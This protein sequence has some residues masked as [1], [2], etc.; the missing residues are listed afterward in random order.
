MSLGDED[1]GA[2][3]SVNVPHEVQAAADAAFEYGFPLFEVMRIC[4]SLPAANRTFSKT[5]LAT[6]D[7]TM[8][9]LPNNDTLYTVAAMYVGSSWVRLTLPARGDRYMSASLFDAYSNNVA[10]ASARDIPRDGG[11]YYFR[12]TGASREGIPDGATVFDCP[13]PFAFLMVRT[14]VSGPSDLEA[15]NAVQKGIELTAN[16]SDAPART[17]PSATTKAEDFF[18]KLMLRLAQNPPPASQ[19]DYVASFA[20]AGIQASRTPTVDAVTSEQRAAW[21]VAYA[22]GFSKLD[23]AEAVVHDQREAW[24][25]PNPNVANP[26]TNY[27]L[28]AVVARIELFALPPQESMY[29]R[30]N[31]DSSTPR[32]LHLPRDWAPIDAGGFWSLTM[33]SKEGYLV[34]NSIERYSIGDRTPGLQKEAD[35]TLKIYVQPTDPGDA[36]STNWLPSPTGPYSMT[37]RLYLPNRTALGPTFKLPALE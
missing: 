15:A 35:G 19:A 23:A 10:L 32:V 25:F 18:L 6:A 33:Y 34:A 30:T 20:K 31:A 14:L 3:E 36:R 22:N 2:G 21:E 28:R 9:V 4:E 26:G 24:S 16:S 17:A 5:A 7:D 1:H 29:P 27:A 8:V 13:T 11:I 12:Q 37:L